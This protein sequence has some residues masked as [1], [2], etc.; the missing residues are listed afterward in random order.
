MRILISILFLLLIQVC[1]CNLNAEKEQKV[2]IDKIKCTEIGI[3]KLHEL[4]SKYQLTSENTERE[5][6]KNKEYEKLYLHNL[7]YPYGVARKYY[8]HWIPKEEM[9][10]VSIEGFK[11]GLNKYLENDE[12]PFRI[13]SYVVWWSMQSC[14]KHLSEKIWSISIPLKG[15]NLPKR[16]LK[17]IIKEEGEERASRILKNYYEFLFEEIDSKYSDLS[18]VISEEEKLE[19]IINAMQGNFTIK[20]FMEEQFDNYR[21]EYDFE[22]IVLLEYCLVYETMKNG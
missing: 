14:L 6:I 17:K 4:L 13:G 10:D 7:V 21:E 19:V 5:W 15:R 9:I 11:K 20:D 8:L 2:N 3:E 12:R 16:E 1:S 22:D 18:I